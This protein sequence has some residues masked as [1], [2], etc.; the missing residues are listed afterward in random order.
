MARSEN[1][2]CIKCATESADIAKKRDCWNVEL[3]HNRRSYYRRRDRFNSDRRVARS[4]SKKLAVPQPEIP[5]YAILYVERLGK[6][7]DAKVVG[8]YAKYYEGG[9]KV[10]ETEPFRAAALPSSIWNQYAV[11]ILKT[12]QNKYFSVRG[13]IN[14]VDIDVSKK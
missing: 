2:E 10:D 7:Q 14:S 1:P 11:N 4:Q 12:L 9:R 5:P 3:C 6:A 8:M 13:F